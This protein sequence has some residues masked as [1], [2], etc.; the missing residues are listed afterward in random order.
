MKTYEQTYSPT[1]INSLVIKKEN[2]LIKIN[3]VFHKTLS[4]CFKS[5]V[6]AIF[7]IIINIVING[8]IKF[9]VYYAHNL[10]K[11]SLVLLYLNIALG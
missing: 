1:S 11:I 6:Y 3:K 7:L 8:N 2:K 10:L 9:P 4:I 5:T